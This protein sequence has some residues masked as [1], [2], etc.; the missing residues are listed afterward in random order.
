MTAEKMQRSP[1][2]G[3]LGCYRCGEVFLPKLQA[4]LPEAWI[5][6]RDVK[7]PGC[8]RSEPYQEHLAHP[9]D[10]NKNPLGWPYDDPT[11]AYDC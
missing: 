1:Q 5:R 3:E 9:S 11:I 2:L 6:F 4:D 10:P 7:C 8:G